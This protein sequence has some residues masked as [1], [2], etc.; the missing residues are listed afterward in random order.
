LAFNIPYTFKRAS[1]FGLLD[2]FG[3]SDTGQLSKKYLLGFLFFCLASNSLPA[4]ITLYAENFT[5]DRGQVVDVPISL[6]DFDEILSMQFS[7]NWDTTV[8]RFKEVHSFTASL[9]Q[10]GENEVGTTGVSSG[11]LIVVWFDNSLN[12]ISVADSTSILTLKFEVIGNEGDKSPITFSNSPAV[13]EVVDITSTIIDPVLEHGEVLIPLGMLTSAS[14]LSSPNG[15]RL[16]QNHPNPFDKHT[17]VQASFNTAE[18]VTFTITDAQ[19]KSIY[20]ERFQSKVGPNNLQ[21][22]KEILP[23]SGIYNYTIQSEAYQLS[24]QM[25]LLP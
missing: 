19:G 23:T 7:L 13:I 6:I 9:P 20:K 2:L 15:M 17:T 16:F 5:A 1:L 3:W 18:W 11:N 21:I 10:F 25:I 8:L 12:G 14:D 22:S 4:Q 24:K